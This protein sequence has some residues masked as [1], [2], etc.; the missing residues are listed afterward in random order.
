MS[1]LVACSIDGLWCRSGYRLGCRLDADRNDC[2]SLSHSGALSIKKCEW[3]W[4]ISDEWPDDASCTYL[5][6]TAYVCGTLLET[7]QIESKFEIRIWSICKWA[8]TI[9]LIDWALP[10]G[11]QIDKCGFDWNNLSNLSNLGRSSMRHLQ[12]M[13]LPTKKTLATLRKL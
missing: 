9:E 8:H 3:W 5:I 10:R 6:T 12:L 13:N 4:F 11:Q 1:R 2:K 7:L